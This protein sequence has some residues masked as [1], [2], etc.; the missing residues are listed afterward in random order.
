[1]APCSVRMPPARSGCREGKAAA[2]R[3]A[4]SSRSQARGGQHSRSDLVEPAG[5]GELYQEL[6]RQTVEAVHDEHVRL[7]TLNPREGGR[8]AV[9]VSSPLAPLIPSSLRMS[10]SKRPCFLQ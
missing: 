7:M 9:S 3:R 6:V 5:H 10:T 1:M 8:Q 4:W 2:E